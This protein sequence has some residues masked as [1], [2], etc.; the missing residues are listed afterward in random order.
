MIRHVVMWTFKEENKRA[1]L[2]KFVEMGLDLKDRIPQIRKIDVGINEKPGAEAFDV[3]L[4]ADFESYAD[5][6]AYMAHPE[7]KELIEFVKRVRVLRASVD[8]TI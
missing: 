5:L 7:H 2:E 8:Y 6:D 4:V 3:T 1:N